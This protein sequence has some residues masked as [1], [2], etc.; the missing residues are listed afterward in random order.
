MFNPKNLIV[1]VPILALLL[2]A[3]S[4]AFGPGGVALGVLCGLGLL[5]VSVWSLLTDERAPLVKL[6]VLLRRHY[7]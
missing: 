7:L 6:R 4:G 3:I 1:A 5:G 2:L